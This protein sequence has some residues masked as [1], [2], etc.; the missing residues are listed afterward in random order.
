M[1]IWK[2]ILAILI[3]ALSVILTILSIAGIVGNWFVNH[4]MTDDI[5][6]VLT[7]V[8]NALGLAD[9]ALG[10][11]DTRVGSARERV[12]DFEETVQTAGENFAGNPVILRTLS[13]EP[14]LGIAP[15]VNDL[16]E[17]VQSARERVIGIQH[18]VQAINALPFVSVGEKVSNENRLQRLS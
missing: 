6:Q 4:S 17:S 11:L 5:L 1:S 7:G 18:A 15:A 9:E 16:R 13:E 3:M 12:A 14:D 2:R 10:R 8:E